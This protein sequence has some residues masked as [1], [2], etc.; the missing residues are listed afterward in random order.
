MQLRS[1]SSMSTSAI[2]LLLPL[3]TSA[4]PVATTTTE[5][6]GPTPQ[7]TP[8][9]MPTPA[10]DPLSWL[11][12]S[13]ILPSNFHHNN[14]DDDDDAAHLDLREIADNPAGAAQPAIPT[15]VSP[16]TTLMLWQTAAPGA[17]PQQVQVVYTQVFAS[18]PDQWEG[19]QQG[20]VG[21][22]T[23]KGTVGVVKTNNNDK[24]DAR[25][26]MAAPGAE[27]RVAQPEA[28]VIPP[29]SGHGE[30]DARRLERRKGGKGGS[31][32]GGDSNGVAARV[33]LCASPPT[34]A[35]LIAVVAGVAW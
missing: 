33:A 32:S 18:V 28:F 26:T 6:P 13:T 1:S 34:L 27:R 8:A 22:G 21:M 31:G 19:P 12:I 4:S 5:T 29:E 2:L 10:L 30:V 7:L 11:P 24:R 17:A 20:E 23:I 3:L 25:P 9:P 35:L 16:V 14:G 15:Q